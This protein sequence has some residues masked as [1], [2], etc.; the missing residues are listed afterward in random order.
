MTDLDRTV[1]HP[2]PFSKALMPTLIEACAGFPEGSLLV[3]PFAGIGRAGD[4]AAVHGYR[5]V[6]VELEPEY[7]EQHPDV[8]V[9]DSTELTTLI[10]PGTV[11][12][13]VTSPTYGGRMADQYLGSPKD[14]EH[15]AATGKIRRRTYAVS[16]R[17]TL[18][19]N[20]TGRYQ[21]GDRY[22]LLHID[23]WQECF[24]VLRPGGRMVLNVSNHIRKH[25]EQRVADW[26]DGV[27]QVLGFVR[28]ER[29]MVRTPRY[30]DGAN[31][32]A[33]VA[34]EYVFIY[35]RP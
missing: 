34:A 15:E 21:W 9:G 3:D 22:R 2:C 28:K 16:L 26:H 7:A 17:R 1:E 29:I 10:P 30:R 6:G 8:L 4:I 20:N 25:E 13:I 5:F 14:R 33:R 18:A 32:D 12:I 35:E 27:L 31:R 19:E 23:V 24:K 11:D